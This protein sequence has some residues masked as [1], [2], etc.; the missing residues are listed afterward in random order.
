MSNYL[1]ETVVTKHATTVLHKQNTTQKTGPHFNQPYYFATSLHNCHFDWGTGTLWASQKAVIQDIRTDTPA[2][3]GRVNPNPGSG[4]GLRFGKLW[5][6]I[7][8][9]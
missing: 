4:H 8:I 1:L 9:V 5:F 7:F 6:K 3:S 2:Q